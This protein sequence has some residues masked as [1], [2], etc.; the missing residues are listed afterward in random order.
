MKKALITGISG[1][2]GSYLAA[3][4]LEQGYEVHGT[5]R[6]LGT[7]W[8]RHEL[9]GITNQVVR[10]ECDLLDFDAVLALII[11]LQ[12]DEVYH[13][14]AA[15]SVDQSFENPLGTIRT[16]FLATDTLLAACLTQRDRIRFLN[17]SSAEIFAPSDTPLTLESARRPQSPYGYGKLLSH[18]LVESYRNYGQLFA[19]NAVLFPHE[20][21]LR[22]KEGFITRTI[23][24]ALG[25]KYGKNPEARI[26][27]GN[28]EN[29]RDFGTARDYVTALY[30]ALQTDTA[31]DYVIGTGD[32][33][34][35]GDI[36]YY[37]VDSVG[38]PREVIV[39]DTQ[40]YSHHPPR[41][42]SDPSE[43]QI[44]LGWVN[45]SDIRDTIQE[46]L[47]VAERNYKSPKQ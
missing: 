31:R 40:R 43:T 27:V 24:T 18:E 1:Q 37:I 5:T 26:V 17:A 30:L 15:S 16:A 46:M 36:L 21:I 25:I 14:A 33:V 35:V 29:E 11:R 10:H 34:K 8:W 20:S 6:G 2:D 22:G 3:L 42:I 12:P 4:L 45:K 44:S 41:V 32:A 47:R 7:N 9:L 13:L 19:V 23:E 38:M 28:I 39:F